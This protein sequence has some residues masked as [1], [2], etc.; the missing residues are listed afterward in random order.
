MYE[1]R[2]KAKDRAFVIDMNDMNRKKAYYQ[3]SFRTGRHMN[4]KDRPRKKNWMKELND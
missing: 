2:S 4:E 1:V 3:V